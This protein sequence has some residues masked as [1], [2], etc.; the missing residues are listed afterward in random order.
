[1]PVAP[2]YPDGKPCAAHTYSGQVGVPSI[3]RILQIGGAVSRCSR[4]ALGSR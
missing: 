3:K 1:V 4:K 2:T